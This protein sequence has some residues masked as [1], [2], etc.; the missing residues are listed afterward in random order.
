M[1]PSFETSTALDLY[2]YA[3]DAAN[4]LWTF[5]STV[6]L[7]VVGFA[8]SDKVGLA[9]PQRVVLS[10]AFVVFALA[11]CRLVF[12]NQE[13]A[14]SALNLAHDSGAAAGSER[15]A[16]LLKQARPMKPLKVVAGHVVGTVLVVVATWGAV[17]F[18]R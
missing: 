16:D 15:L 14:Q 12:K 7:A 8:L 5:Y 13:F 3:T 2:K 18:N 17:I 10:V 9:G 6:A 11:N 1:Q 4:R